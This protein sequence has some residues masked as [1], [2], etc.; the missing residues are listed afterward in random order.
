MIFVVR[1]RII[2][3]S[4]YGVSSVSFVGTCFLLYPNFM[5]IKCPL[6]RYSCTVQG[7]FLKCSFV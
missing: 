7:P 1:N 6:E 5:L 3:N 2:G 4:I